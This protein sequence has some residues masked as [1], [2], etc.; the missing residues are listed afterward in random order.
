M[1]NHSTYPLRPPRSIKA[2][3]TSIEGRPWD[4]NGWSGGVGAMETDPVELGRLA[5]T[6]YHRQ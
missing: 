2:D 3:D 4:V 6:S 5:R 1:K